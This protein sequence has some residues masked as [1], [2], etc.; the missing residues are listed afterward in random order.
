ML[1]P[2]TNNRNSRTASRFVGISH[3]LRLFRIRQWSKNLFVFTGLLLSM[4]ALDLVMVQHSIYA[5]LL[6]C[7]ISSTVYILNDMVDIEKDRLHPV[8][9]YRPLPAGQIKVVY[10]AI[11]AIVLCA[12]V[13]LLAYRL[14][15]YF[16]ITLSAYFLLNLL[17]SFKLKEYVFV[18][19]IIISSGFV[20][21][22]LSG[23]L[24]VGAEISMWFLL[25]IA[26]LTLFLGVN[27]RKKELLLLKDGSKAHRKN[28][29]QYSISMINEMIPMLTAC[30]VLSYAFFIIYESTSPYMIITIPMVLYGIF[31]YQYLTNQTELGESPELVLLKDRPTVMIMLLWAAMYGLNMGVL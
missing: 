31:R 26:F 1:A 11:T 9:R 16:G 14:H 27:K 13:L 24:I 21:R 10:A 3:Y 12:G 4:Q 7:G 18:D 17:Y 23:I 30:T 19:I 8:K 22:A 29:S 5:F 25:S 2:I 20:L 15:M 6:F 28:L